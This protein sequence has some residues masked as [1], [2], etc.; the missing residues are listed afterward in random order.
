MSQ[1]NLEGKEF[2][3]VKNKIWVEDEETFGDDEAEVI[4]LTVGDSIEGLLL[5]KRQS[6]LYGNV[7]VIKVKD[8]DKKK[9]ICGTTLLNR[10]MENKEEGTLVRII[11]E[12]D[13]KTNSGRM[14]HMYK[15]YHLEED[16]GEGEKK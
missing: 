4:K 14:A 12:D 5:E 1:K 10:K 7:F 16:K 2:P 15:T 3:D 11:R 13:F 6:D 8:D 9:I